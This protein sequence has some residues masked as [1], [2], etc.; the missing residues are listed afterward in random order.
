MII[1][2][3]TMRI[4]S[5]LILG[6]I[7]AL[8]AAG[9][10]SSSSPH[11][12]SGSVF[13]APISAELLGIAPGTTENLTANVIVDPGTP[14]ERTVPLTVNSAT[15]TVDGTVDGLT[16]GTHVFQI[17]FL[18]NGNEVASSTISANIT[19]GQ[20]TQVAF[21]PSSIQLTVPARRLF[22]SPCRSPWP[23]SKRRTRS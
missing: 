18:V 7:T 15:D 10:G 2:R 11:S 21:D 12:G 9:C 13:S 14:N 17:V 22:P 5:L 8:A 3:M 1:V 16:S 23:S 19:P 4:F 20:T 6:L